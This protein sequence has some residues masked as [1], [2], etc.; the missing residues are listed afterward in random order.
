LDPKSRNGPKW[1]SFPARK[2]SDSEKARGECTCGPGE[3]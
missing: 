1:S 2:R 3:M